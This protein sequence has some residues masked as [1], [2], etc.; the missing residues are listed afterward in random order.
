VRI[1]VV[2]SSQFFL[3]LALAS[4]TAGEVVGPIGAVWRAS[5]R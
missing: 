1:L 2:S 3:G 4:T 5:E